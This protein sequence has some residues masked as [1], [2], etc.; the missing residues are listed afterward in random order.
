[1]GNVEIIEMI[2]AIAIR[3]VIFAI[4]MLVS[5]VV[6]LVLLLCGVDGWLVMA[7][8]FIMGA[9][10]LLIGDRSVRPRCS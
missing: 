2:A 8:L 3:A 1:M 5:L 7:L 9:I 10:S 4:I 6:A